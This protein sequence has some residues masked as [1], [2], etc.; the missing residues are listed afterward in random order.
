VDPV[1]D[2]ASM[3]PLMYV[4]SVLGA[5]LVVVMLF[6]AANPNWLRRLRRR[7]ARP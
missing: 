4:P 5:A 1:R 2:D 3:W 7:E 6:Q